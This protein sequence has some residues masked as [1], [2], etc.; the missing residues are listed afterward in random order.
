MAGL[1]LVA[2]LLERSGAVAGPDADDVL[3]IRDEIISRLPDGD[4]LSVHPSGRWPS[5]GSG[6][7]AMVR[8]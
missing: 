1:V 2:Q 5:D 7:P 4:S 6:P 8:R 3:R